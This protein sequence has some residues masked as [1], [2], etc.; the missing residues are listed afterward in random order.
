[1]FAADMWLQVVKTNRN[2]KRW[3][4]LPLLFRRLLAQK[5]WN[6]IDHEDRIMAVL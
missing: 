3:F 6:E 2:E 1:V 4:V 5:F